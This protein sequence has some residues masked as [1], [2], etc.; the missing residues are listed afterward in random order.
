MLIEGAR[1]V[2]KSTLAE[3]FGKNEYSSYL[4]IDFFQAPIE[5]KKYFED[6]RTDFDTL[7]LYL[8][9]FYGVT[10]VKGDSLV[11]F[12]EV[13]MFPQARGFNKI[14]SCRWTLRLY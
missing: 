12:D 7:F 6:Y 10:L 1:R 5:V 14:F 3:T 2:G 11:V 13:Q 4:V 8:Q 9:V